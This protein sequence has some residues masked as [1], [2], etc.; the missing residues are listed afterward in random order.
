MDKIKPL[1]SATSAGGRSKY[2]IGIANLEE[3]L[4]TSRTLGDT[5]GALG[6]DGL[7]C[8]NA[9]KVLQCLDGR[10]IEALLVHLISTSSGKEYESGAAID[11]S[12]DNCVI[13]VSALP[14][15][16]ARIRAALLCME[17]QESGRSTISIREI[18][19]DPIRR[20]VVKGDQLLHLTPKEFDLLHYLMARPGIPVRHAELLR[21][22]WGVEY[23]DELE[24]LRTYIYHLRQKL[25]DNPT[26]PRHLLTEPYF[27]YRFA[28]SEAR[29]RGS[30][31]LN[32]AVQ[33]AHDVL[34]GS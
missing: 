12:A 16:I 4:G 13:N 9:K 25:E 31:P 27:G 8:S 26:I 3:E 2:F 15:L 14:E 23:G 11:G 29:R 5:V 1:L 6:L 17:L 7:A 34:A 21:K 32:S 20:M 30:D 33:F 28:D 19:L 18:E 24:Y 10:V 22:I